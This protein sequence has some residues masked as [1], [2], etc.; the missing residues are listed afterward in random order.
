MTASATT[1]VPTGVVQAVVAE[2]AIEA[3]ITHVSVTA[4]AVTT[5]DLFTVPSFLLRPWA[6][7]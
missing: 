7:P 3:A 5:N 1:L 4:A 6:G 2:S